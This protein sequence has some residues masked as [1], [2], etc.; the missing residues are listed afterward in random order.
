MDKNQGMLIVIEGIDGAGKTTQIELLTKYLN[1]RSIPHEVISFPRYED[2]LYGKLIR[3]YLKGEFGSIQNVN[4]YLMA[5]AYAGDRTLAKPLIESFLN[6]GKV[7]IA[8]RYAS[9]S[10]AHLGANLPEDKREEF[11]R[12]LDELEYQTNGVPKEDLVI[13]L[14]V[15]PTIGQKN[16]RG[17]HKDIHEKDLSHLKKASDIY[18]ELAKAE[19]NWQVV[20]CVVDDKMRSKEDIH[21]DLTALLEDRLK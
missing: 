16:V 3:R 10:K 2:N 21:K 18:L 7:V 19:E 13:L 5:L 6:G 14:K 9:S 11:M 15:D 4:P 8:N 17:E 12:W 1:E 20:N